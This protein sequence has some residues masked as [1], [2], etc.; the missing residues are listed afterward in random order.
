MK[1]FALNQTEHPIYTFTSLENYY[2]LCLVSLLVLLRGMENNNI[3]II[4]KTTSVLWS[5]IRIS[6]TALPIYMCVSFA[7]FEKV[8]L[9]TI[10]VSFS[11]PLA[12]EQAKQYQASKSEYACS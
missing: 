11:F 4:V 12:V 5:C 1:Y 8:S 9:S 3:V 2:I 10:M 6:K 7:Q